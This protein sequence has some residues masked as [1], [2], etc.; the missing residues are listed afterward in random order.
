MILQ[1][2]LQSLKRIQKLNPLQ[3]HSTKKPLMK[4]KMVLSKPFNPR[5]LSSTSLHILRISSLETK[6]VP[7]EQDHISNKRSLCWDC[8]K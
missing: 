7:E 2:I 4:N 6:K 5:T 3:K 8:Y 1:I